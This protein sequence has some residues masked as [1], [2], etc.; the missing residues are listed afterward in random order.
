MSPVVSCRGAR[1]LGERGAY[2]Q[3]AN[4]RRHTNGVPLQARSQKK[5]VSGGGSAPG[6]IRMGVSMEGPKVPSEAREGAKRR[7]VEAGG[8]SGRGVL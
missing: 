6:N 4:E 1:G 2:T 5:N 3:L 7:N 8:A